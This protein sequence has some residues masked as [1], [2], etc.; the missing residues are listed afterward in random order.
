[1]NINKLTEDNYIFYA[2]QNYDNSEC[3]TVDDFYEDINK[4]KYIKRLLRRY[5]KLGELREQLIFN[6]IVLLGNVFG[7]QVTA[8][9]L[10]FKLEKRL[11]PALK[12]FL[13]F[14][15]YMQDKVKSINTLSSDI[16]LDGKLIDKLRKV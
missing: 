1:M 14:L 6:H 9:L 11:W 5:D 12:T 4:I 15:G 3:N 7:P 10:F 8:E 16:E 2:M 13:I